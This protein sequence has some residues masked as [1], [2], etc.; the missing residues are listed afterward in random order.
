M[1]SLNGVGTAIK[2]GRERNGVSNC[3]GVE[4]PSPLDFE[5]K[6]FHLIRNQTP[7]DYRIRRITQGKREAGIQRRR[8]EQ[9]RTTPQG[10]TETWT[11]AEDTAAEA[12]KRS[13]TQRRVEEAGR[14]RLGIIPGVELTPPG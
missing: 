9:R 10:P 14:R 3:Q 4:A 5:R 8:R 2:L 6:K 13:G 12:G 1:G 11:Q 7:E